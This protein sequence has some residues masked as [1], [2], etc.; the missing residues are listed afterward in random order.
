MSNYN[1]GDELIYLGNDYTVVGEVAAHYLLRAC[2][3]ALEPNTL[4]VPIHAELQATNPLQVMANLWDSIV[5]DSAKELRNVL[6]NVY[7]PRICDS[8]EKI[9]SSIVMKLHTDNKFTLTLNG[10]EYDRQF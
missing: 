1:T 7:L 4:S 6:T 8:H 2:D 9:P 5:A 10:V 3:P